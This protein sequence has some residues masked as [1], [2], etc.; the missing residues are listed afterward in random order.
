MKNTATKIDALRAQLAAL[1]KV[2]ARERGRVIAKLMKLPAKF[3]FKS[4][5]EFI[6][7]LQGL[8]PAY[9]KVPGLNVPGIAKPGRKAKA[10]KR[11]RTKMTPEIM[12][13][14]KAMFKDKKTDAEISKALGI[15]R[16]TVQRHKP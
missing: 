1:E 15:N 14:M 11:H 5:Q 16:S 8:L 10:G 7:E 3:G 2:A 6:A 4:L 9:R 13:K 12:D